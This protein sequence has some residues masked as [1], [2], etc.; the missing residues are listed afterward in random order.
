MITLF[1]ERIRFLKLWMDLRIIASN[2]S[3]LLQIISYEILSKL[4][5][6]KNLLVNLFVGNSHFR[7]RCLCKIIPYMATIETGTIT[8]KQLHMMAFI[9]DFEIINKHI[10]SKIQRS[11]LLGNIII[12]FTKRVYNKTKI[13]FFIHITNR[14]TIK[15]ET[16]FNKMFIP[17]TV[18]IHTN[19]FFQS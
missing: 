19:S 1:V 9:A 8:F 11:S 10:T 13:L 7:H 16:G 18:E 6:L 17:L 12:M 15:V 4:L 5:K 2:V 14:S 3:T